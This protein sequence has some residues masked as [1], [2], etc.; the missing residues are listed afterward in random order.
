M[1]VSW[2]C[3][4]THDKAAEW[5]PESW[6]V[7]PSGLRMGA[8]QEKDQES[9][10]K[11]KSRQAASNPR[12]FRQSKT[13]TAF[14]FSSWSQCRLFEEVLAVPVVMFGQ[15]EDDVEVNE[16]CSRAAVLLTG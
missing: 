10:R 8:V 2:C 6:V 5:V 4:M 16:R 11:V 15:N 1:V 9:K 13:Y 3:D 14:D 12:R 7:I